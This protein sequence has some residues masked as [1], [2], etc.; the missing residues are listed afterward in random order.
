MMRRL[1][2]IAAIA[3]VLAV[4]ATALAGSTTVTINP[5]KDNSLYEDPLGELSNGAG[6]YLFAGRTLQSFQGD[7]DLRRAL[8]AFDVAGSLP[9]GATILD[10]TL[11]LRVTRDIAGPYTFTVHRLTSDWGEGSSDAFG[12]E[13]IGVNPGPGDASW[14]HT[15]YDTNTWTASGGDFGAASASTTV[16]GAGFFYSWSSTQLRDDVQ[17]MLDNAGTN[18]G[19]VIVGDETTFPTAKQFASRE[20]PTVSHRPTLEITYIAESV[21]EY[22]QGPDGVNTLEVNGDNGLGSGNTVIVDDAGPIVFSIDKPAAG[23]NGKFFVHMNVGAPSVDTLDSL[24]ANLGDSC[25]TYILNR[26]AAFVANWNSLGKVDK[27]GDNV[28]FGTPGV[29]PGRAPQTF[30]NLPSGDVTNLPMGSTFTIQGVIINPASSSP[31]GV[32]QTNAIVVEVQ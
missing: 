5:S 19:W 9:A 18:F 26:G 23:G 15:F 14:I 6:V 3:A 20:N 7:P 16:G 10:A 28:Y 17:D 25:F 32:S 2:P 24:P 8:L 30:L 31:K 11:T 1:T 21:L 29:S 12:E 4:A 22:C 13:G 27:I